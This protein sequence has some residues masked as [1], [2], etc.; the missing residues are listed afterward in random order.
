MIKVANHRMPRKTKLLN[1]RIPLSSFS[2]SLSLLVTI[3]YS[4]AW[5]LYWKMAP[6][7]TFSKLPLDPRR[8]WKLNKVFFGVIVSN[9]SLIPVGISLVKYR[10]WARPDALL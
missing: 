4:V 10:Y 8:I 6:S 2:F 9:I 7:T 1:K 5:Y 3:L